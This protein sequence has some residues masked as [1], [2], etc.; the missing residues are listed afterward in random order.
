MRV[1]V[2]TSTDNGKKSLQFAS[3]TSD[4]NLYH[5]SQMPTCMLCNCLHIVQF[6]VILSNHVLEYDLRLFFRFQ[7]SSTSTKDVEAP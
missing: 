1:E 5:Y 3:H 6:E 7:H 2:A 4:C